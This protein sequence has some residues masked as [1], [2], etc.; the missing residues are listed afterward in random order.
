[1][2]FTVQ[3][4]PVHTAQVRNMNLPVAEAICKAVYTAAETGKGTIRRI[5]PN[6]RYRISI[7]VNGAIAYAH[8]DPD[9]LTLTVI[10][11][12]ATK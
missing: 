11:I 2:K 9:A 1:M 8:V 12:V 7:H 6:N 3:W 10:R 4:H 5:H